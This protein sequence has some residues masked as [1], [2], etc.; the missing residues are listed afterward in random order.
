MDLLLIHFLLL[1]WL[2][3]LAAR[4]LFAPAAEQWL[5]AALLA[6]ANLAA[7][8]LVLSP[9]QRLGSPVWYLAISLALAGTGWLATRRIAEDTFATPAGP[10]Q[11]NRWLLAGLGAILASLAAASVLAAA[12]YVPNN[13]GTMTYGLPR[14][15]YYLGHGSLQPFTT[16]DARLV[17]LP[18]GYPLLQLFALAYAPPWV[19]V[20]FLNIAAWALA[21]IAI[22]RCSRL[23]SAGV[24]AALATALLTL[25]LPAI[26]AQA[27]TT[28]P[29]LAVGTAL[30]ASLLFARRWWLGRRDRD[31]W[32]AGLAGGLASASDLRAAG[33]VA[34]GALVLL[35]AAR[36]TSRPVSRAWLQ[37][38][39]LAVVLNLPF[40]ALMYGTRAAGA[41]TSFAPS[42]G[43][44]LGLGPGERMP[45]LG[46]LALHEDAIGFG[47]AG[48]LFVVLP[49]V[50]RARG[51]GLFPLLGV[52]W[53]GFTW[54]IPRWA[55]ASPRD[56]IPT[57]LLLAPGLALALEGSRRLPRAGR[58]AVGGLVAAALAAS[59]LADRDYLL[60]NVRRPL[61]PVRQHQGP[62]PALSPLPVEIHYHLRRQ[63]RVNIDS[64]GANEVIFPLMTLRHAQ[65]F[66][67]DHTLQPA[68][69]NLISRSTLSRE[70]ALEHLGTRASY[71][72]IPM[73]A[74][75][76]AGAEFIARVGTGADARDYFGVPP[77]AGTTAPV[78]GNRA[79]LV[80]VSGTT[81]QPRLQLAGLNAADHAFVS[82]ELKFADT[83]TEP[84]AEWRADGEQVVTVAKPFD[85]LVFRARDLTTGREL[86]AA[87]LPYHAHAPAAAAAAAAAKP[88][89]PSQPTSAQSLFV[90]DMVLSS[91][92]TA[93]ASEGLTP[94]EGPFPQWDLPHI[95]WMRTPA[96]QLR[97]PPIAD[98]A[99]LQIDYAL[100]LHARN[101][102][103]L[104]I[105]LNGRVVQ[106]EHL[107]GR[108]TWLERRLELTPEPGENVV[109]FRDVS[110][111]AEPD[112]A[113]YLERY[114]DV[115][116][117]LADS[118]QPLLEG[119]RTHYEKFGR[120]E[121]R[122]LPTKE[123][124]APPPPDSFYFMFRHLRLEGFRSP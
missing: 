69:F 59:L 64:D 120:T 8:S 65:R 55:P 33:L 60:H 112:W 17:I 34:T 90:E 26:L 57:V 35:V 48:L 113:E 21:G 36:R 10:D 119:A 87:A 114:P 81:Q 123:T 16:A 44:P 107:E 27:A 102:G 6:W 66:T 14:V 39:L 115:K 37:A 1:L 31:A 122:T 84:L 67:F 79:L 73:P 25:T 110:R 103:D 77:A 92:P 89:D 111:G 74:K 41:A 15:L 42:T 94:V 56:L 101:A 28:T 104:E 105:L 47:L 68:A 46:G 95:R 116:R 83:T 108:A 76:S 93:A 2:S 30:L 96:I 82:V 40:L 4:R 88:V 71:V 97:L 106:R 52:A 86:G 75:P 11:P 18:F 7:T 91:H 43:T 45:F 54:V 80:T 72:R 99:R 109:E 24:N 3:L 13:P 124:P 23:G 100:R 22:Y 63:P 53:L 62:A 5:A 19:V 20:N 58:L 38:V 121:G 32:F 85:W 98:L 50:T 29:E 49:L 61:E 118:N 117:S 12:L 51:A 78:D 70:S 9:A